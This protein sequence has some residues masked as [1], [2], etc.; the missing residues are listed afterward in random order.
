MHA[1]LSFVLVAGADDGPARRIRSSTDDPF[2]GA[3]G[4]DLELVSQ[5]GSKCHAAKSG[6]ANGPFDKEKRA[7]SLKN[8]KNKIKKRS[9][10]A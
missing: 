1:Q 2:D 8:I 7:E 3:P 4:L 5:L 10:T 6:D 9:Q